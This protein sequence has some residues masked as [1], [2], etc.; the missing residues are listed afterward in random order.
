MDDSLIQAREYV[1]REYGS[2]QH[3]YWTKLIGQDPIVMAHPK[4]ANGRIEVEPIWDRGRPGGAI[5]V[6]ISVYEIIPRKFR[7]RVPTVSY[8]VFEDGRLSLFDQ[9]SKD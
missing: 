6:I 8:L 4:D 1:L 9:I 5:R 3:A 7:V 2:K